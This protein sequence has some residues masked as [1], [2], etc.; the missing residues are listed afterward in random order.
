LGSDASPV[1]TSTYDNYK[2]IVQWQTSTDANR[3][4]ALRLR[5]N[6]TDLS[7][8]SYRFGLQ[9]LLHDGSAFNANSAGATSMSLVSNA[10]YGDGFTSTINFDINGP[11]VLNEKSVFGFAQGSTG[12]ATANQRIGGL[13]TSTAAYNGFTLLNSSGNFVNTRVMVYGYRRA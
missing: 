3:T 11:L 2:I 9:G 12:A 10:Y 8:S 6:T 13:V 7:S 5:A 1:F 4:I